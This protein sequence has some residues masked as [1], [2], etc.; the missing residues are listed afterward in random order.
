MNAITGLFGDQGAAPGMGGH[1]SPNAKSEVWLTPPHVLAAL[2]TFD[3]DPCACLEPRLWP[4]ATTHYTRADNGL[5]K[6]WRGRVFLN[7][8]YGGPA[9]I[10]PW[11]RRMA[12]HRHGIALIFA[13]TET[14]A[15]HDYIWPAASAALF[16]RGR[17]F[18]HR[19]DGSQA[20]HNAG[21]PSVLIAYGQDDA[22]IL[23]R[24]DLP[25]FF[26]N[27]TDRSAA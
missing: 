22:E 24:C 10:T 23:R 4:T 11:L 13:R 3:L 19:P 9:V 18:F 15:F 21:A 14:A 7:P 6:P 26:V 1:E 8:P 12:G 5:T 20:A 27:L 25:G 17:L 2:G 16:L